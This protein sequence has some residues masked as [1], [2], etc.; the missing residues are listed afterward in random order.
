MR[1]DASVMHVDADSFFA[2]VETRHKPSLAGTPVLVG[3]TGP[4]GVVATAS[5]EARAF[6]CRSAMPM[7]QARVL[8]PGATVLTPRFPAY[9]AHSALIMD[10][11]RQLSPLVQ[12]VSLDEAFVDLAAGPFAADPVMAADLARRLIYNRSGL[13]VSVGLGRS[14]LIAKLASDADKPHGFTVVPGE[15]EDEFLMPKPVGALWGVGPATEA[16]LRTL[17]IRTV[18]D[19]RAAGREDLVRVLGDAAGWNLYR[20][21]RGDDPRPV[22]VEREAKSVGAERTYAQDLLRWELPGALEDVLARTLRR[23]ARHGGGARTVTVKVRLSDFTTLTRSVT[24]AHPTAEADQLRDAATAA[25]TAANPVE[26]VRLLGVSLSGLTHWAQLRLPEA[27][28]GGAAVDGLNALGVLTGTPFAAGEPDAAVPKVEENHVPG[29]TIEG[30]GLLPEDEEPDDA[31]E[32]LLPTPLTLHSVAVGLDVSHPDHGAGWVMRSEDGVVIVRFE[33][34]GTPPG[35]ERTFD[36][37]RELLMRVSPPEPCPPL[38][39]ASLANLGEVEAITAM[40]LSN[41]ATPP[42]P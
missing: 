39:L 20:L 28:A 11:L 25:L 27:E 37:R 34:P 7:S 42:A 6:G 26:P 14:K 12:P 10:T 38:R 23:L 4:R 19:L 1:E 13:V 40:L 2:S 35:P 30:A 9:A 33:G 17:G 8:C 21:A 29:A 16:T 32:E 41:W 3:G 24:L 15:D 5:Y 31:D 18:A 22:V 36:I